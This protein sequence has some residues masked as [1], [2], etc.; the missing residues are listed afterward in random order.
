MNS[1]DFQGH[2]D[3][4][5]T[6]KREPAAFI[7]HVHNVNEPLTAL[8]YMTRINAMGPFWNYDENKPASNSALRRWLEQGAI[9]FNSERIMPLDLIDFPIYSLVM[10]PKGKRRCTLV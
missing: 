6:L 7:E 4:M 9:L 2:I 8:Q 3:K 5:L 10:F 1:T